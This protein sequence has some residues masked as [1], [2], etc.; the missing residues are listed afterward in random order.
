MALKTAKKRIQ[1]TVRLRKMAIIKICWLIQE[2]LINL[3][4]TRP[5]IKILKGRSYTVE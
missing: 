1:M 2:Y 5:K 4:E 3:R